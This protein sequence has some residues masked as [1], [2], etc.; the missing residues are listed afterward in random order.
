MDIVSARDRNINID[1]GYFEKIASVAS[2]H[3]LRIYK[4]HTEANVEKWNIK[5]WDD[6]L[7]VF[8][9]APEIFESTKISDSVTQYSL[10]DEGAEEGAMK[11]IIEILKAK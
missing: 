5:T 8:I 10:T 11:V 6:I 2:N 1:S 4:G 9:T 3:A 7:V